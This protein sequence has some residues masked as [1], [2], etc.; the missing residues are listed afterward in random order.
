ML[1]QA[2][3]P[4]HLFMCVTVPSHQHFLQSQDL[5]ADA[6]VIVVVEVLDHFERPAP[7]QDIPPHGVSPQRAGTVGTSL[8]RETPRTLFEERIGSSDELVERVQMSSRTFDVLEALRSLS[9]RIH[10]R[11][12]LDVHFHGRLLPL[13]DGVPV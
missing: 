11:V 9:N 7:L 4:H 2:A 1:G 5:G 6:G 10:D 13:I 3:L 12:V 8:S